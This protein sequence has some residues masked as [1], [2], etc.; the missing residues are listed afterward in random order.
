M[1]TR[2]R[3]LGAAV[4]L[5]VVGCGP[6]EQAELEGGPDPA[7][8]SE[9]SDLGHAELAATTTTRTLTAYADTMA[10]ATQPDTG[11]ASAQTLYA[12]AS[13]R[14]QPYLRF[15][16]SGVEGVIT[17]A[18]LRVYVVDGSQDGPAVYGVR[19]DWSV[20][21]LTWNKAPAV[22]TQK[23]AD[24]GAVSAGTWVEYDVSSWV[25]ANV[26]DYAFTLVST[27]SDGTG[28]EANDAPGSN[29]PRLVLTVQDCPGPETAIVFPS[30]DTWVS[31]AEPTR[32]NADSPSL[33]ADGDP[34]SEA[35]LSFDVATS[36]RTLTGARLRLFATGG[37]EDAPAVH[38]TTNWSGGDFDW[39]GRPAVDA[40][41]L[42]DKGS[43]S[44]GT[45]VE[46]DVG[47]AL[48]GDGRYGFALRP[49]G[50]DGMTFTSNQ[51]AWGYW[52][53]LVLSYTA[54]T[55]GYRGPSRVG[56]TLSGRWHMPA[57]G[58]E[59]VVS[60]AATSD[61]GW[62]AL[63]S[64][65]S[66]GSANP[67]DFGGDPLPG[68]QGFA[69]T[70]YHADGAVAW[71]VGHAGQF[72]PAGL[73]V[74]P[75]GHVLVVGRYY[76][77]PDVGT[78]PLPQAAAARLFVTRLSPDGMTEWVRTF[79]SSDSGQPGML[80]ATSLT[81]DPGGAPIVAGRFSGEVD[82]GGGPLHPDGSG[83]QGATALYLVK[84]AADGS[85][86]WSRTFAAS[87]AS[88]P[89]AVAAD[90]AGNLY[91]SGSAP[92]GTE[93][94]PSGSGPTPF[95]ARLTAAGERVWTRAWAGA[96]GATVAVVPYGGDV[97]FSGT[98][99]GAF[100]FAGTTYT[101][102][103]TDYSGSPTDLFLGRLKGDGTDVWLKHVG[104][105]FGESANGLTVTRTGTVVLWAQSSGPVSF[106]GG[107]LRGGPIYAGYS[108]GGTHR[109]SRHL[110]LPA[111][112]TALTTGE[113]LLGATLQDTTQVDGITFSPYAWYGTSV[114][115][116]ALFLRL[117]P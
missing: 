36:G 92:G 24:V 75:T 95:V 93:L 58:D 108:T 66:N 38:A 62:V 98:F 31:Q 104:S 67:P 5:V 22:L 85:H 64:Y 25:K 94:A 13:P 109:W 1:G 59:R 7:A 74:A 84:F 68:T 42:A 37:T 114:T 112:P 77:A 78:G 39:T 111:L 52:P 101:Q 14:R 41:P 69:V 15:T 34:E 80:E 46:Y 83:A 113:L 70:R 82:F 103:P 4:A 73:A 100:S 51:G 56:G 72:L 91:L 16:L 110:P 26:H 2:R 23:L 105:P 29:N 115:S 57:G 3:W 81:T 71:S 9:A 6:M 87:D 60:T 27:T 21:S 107:T 97:F 49:Q 96:N 17:S 53:Q 20:N 55:C 35:Y 33:T 63:G 116:D 88:S 117:R 65:V 99:T 90:S 44:S 79:A 8:P 47:S 11:F 106:G 28:I 43:V 48:S 61:E 50:T 86:A 19:P 102:V 40:T 89:L 54:S 30:F 10:D 76:G 45:W 32:R 18:K 12:D